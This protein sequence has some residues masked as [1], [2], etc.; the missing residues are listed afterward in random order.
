[1]SSEFRRLHLAT[2]LILLLAGCGREDSRPDQSASG[3]TSS[4]ARIDAC[5][6]LTTEEVEAAV[7]EAVGPGAL[8]EHGTAP[9]ES[10]FSICTYTPLAETSLTSVTVTV[11]NSPEVTDPA[12]ALEA[13][14]A[15]MRAN[16][17]P[18]YRLE[19]VETLDAAAGWDPAMGQLTAFRRGLMLVVGVAGPLAEPRR[20]ALDL[21]T[22]ALEAVH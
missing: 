6:L 14:V 3:I 20:T 4:V 17:M 5:S 7:G 13:H 18:G 12:A 10:Y 22:A 21:A 9:D 11:R 19:P 15:D 1:M 16:A 2:L 8:Q